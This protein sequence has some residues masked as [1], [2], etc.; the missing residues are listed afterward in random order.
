VSVASE[1]SRLLGF[2]REMVRIR[3]FED[4]V[5]DLYSRA[6]IPGIAHL[7]SGQE[8][9]AV[10]VC[11]AL[12][13][14]DYITSTHRGH[15]HCLAKGASPGRM[16]AEL[17]GKTDGYCHGR[18][19]SMHIADPTTGN[20]GANAIVGGSLAIAAG[21][22]LS[23]SL[24][25]SGQVVACFIGDGALNQGLLLE[26]MNMA[27]LWS[28]PVIY[29]CEHNRYGEYTRTELAT[30]GDI[31]KRGEA[32]GIPTHVV[33]GMD[34]VAVHEAAAAAVERARSG[35][36]PT[37]LICETYR[38]AGHGMSDRDRPYRT[39][40]E[41]AEWRGR[42]PIDRLERLLLADAVTSEAELAALTAAVD[43]EMLEAIEFAK[44]SPDP[45]VE[46][47]GR[48]VYVD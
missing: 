26:S 45:Q 44:Q 11:E 12:R 31:R 20:L 24:R 2:Y 46:E 35:D 39:R 10:G 41:E 7:S 43:A 8:A 40:E 32:F 27:A 38:Y 19:G 9:V 13:T 33:D 34:V 28:L 3:R 4:H 36:G 29:V 16:F 47:V 37:F 30:A 22:G 21:A 15:G 6:Q 48:Y 23:A 5:D 18:G 17:F 1:P 14:D 42:D 25:D